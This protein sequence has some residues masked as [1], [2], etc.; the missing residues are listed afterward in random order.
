MDQTPRIGTLLNFISNLLMNTLLG[1]LGVA[2]AWIF[3]GAT[4]VGLGALFFRL[5][6]RKILLSF[7]CCFWVGLVLLVTVLQV[8]NLFWG[9]NTVVVTSICIVGLFSFWLYRAR[10]DVTFWPGLEPWQKL[11]FTLGILWIADRALAGTYGPYVYDSGLYHFAS[12][13]WANEQ[14]LPPGLGNLHG[15][16]A[17]NQS[18]FLFVSFLNLLPE[19]GYGH[20]FANSLLLLFTIITITEKG[21]EITRDRP[22]KIIL[23]LLVPLLFFFALL[24]NQTNEPGI[25]SPSPDLAMLCLQLAMF[26]LALAVCDRISQESKEQLTAEVVGVLLIAGLAVTFK[27][28]S[29]VFAVGVAVFV[30]IVSSFKSEQK[31][32]F[33][34]ILLSLVNLLVLGSTWVTR[35]VI[36]SGYLIYPIAAT[37]CPVSWRVPFDQVRDEANWILSWPR[38]P[39]VHWSKVLADWSWFRPWLNRVTVRPDF[40]LGL[41]L[42]GFAALL[43][44]F[45]FAASPKRTL[46]SLRGCSDFLALLGVC[47][48]A[49]SF[50]FFTAPDPRFLGAVFALLPLCL[51]GV[52]LKVTQ[53]D[54][55]FSLAVAGA[56]LI[57][58]VGICLA[59]YANGLGLNGL[60]KLRI[61]SRVPVAELLQKV[62]DSGLRVWVPVVS[63]QTWDA[64]LP[65]T[66]YFRRDLRL[67]G[68]DLASGFCFGTYS[69]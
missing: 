57:F 26:A 24:Y 41:C 28:S 62:T 40:V 53:S 18:Y 20:N 47:T 46:K 44:V 29:I 6:S 56:K 69:R 14:P 15:R 21:G 30:V 65:T 4:I 9:I 61:G 60:K 58:A 67:R 2:L 1:N 5:I 51:L 12:V 45:L 66:P 31:A 39:G 10:L 68:K 7:S 36:A 52:G 59:L 50:W 13:R 35:S 3:Y 25:C 42:L 33:P 34:A 63:D 55:I 37:G 64:P 8:I 48:A 38:Q 22:R 54:R 32:L 43:I 16:L 23:L 17:F 11:L 19:Q 49:L 27:L